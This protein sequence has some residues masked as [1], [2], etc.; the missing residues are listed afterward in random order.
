MAYG[1][2]AKATLGVDTSQVPQD[3]AKARAAFKK[4]ADDIAQDSSAH[5]ANAGEKFV[6]GVEHKLL[7]ASHLSTAFATA[8]GLNVEK[9][10]DSIAE[11][12]TRGSKEGW[13][14]A[15]D[16]AEEN[17]KLIASRVEAGMS[18]KQ[19]GDH[20]KRE[21]QK[22]VEEQAS[23][24]KQFSTRE[25]FVPGR[26]EAGGGYAPGTTRTVAN[27]ELTAEQTEKL[28]EAR[29][30]VL[31]IENRLA[32]MQKEE[33]KEIKQLEDQSLDVAEKKGTL[34]ERQQAIQSHMAIIEKQ[35]ESGSLT[36]VEIARKKV[37]LDQKRNDLEE[38]HRQM[39]Q[40][41]IDD[42]KRA[43]ELQSKANELARQRIE[44]QKD[45]DKLTDRSKL[46]VGELAALATNKATASQQDAAEAEAARAK[47]FQF[48]RDADLTPE[49]VKA[50]DQAEEIERLQ[51]KAER[52]RLS[53][54]Q[55]GA[56]AA[57]DQ[58][59]TLRESLVKSGFT[60]STEG[61]PAKLLLEQVKKDNEQVIKTL[62]EIKTLEAGKYVNQ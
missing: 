53:G 58:V 27:T 31:E 34:L 28:E 2:E 9:I 48:G 52:A 19:L 6:K 10:A 22:A 30:R 33:K 39:R 57:L 51:R 59:G 11:A 13:K 4:G 18:Q 35:I 40:K 37:E 15:G 23:L 60:K 14:R 20:L 32:E 44:L 26:R 29:K 17:A 61:D 55:A 1:S 62:G 7:G 43:N 5:G 42:E 54:D 49:Q 41:A 56:N 38:V 24:A 36:E 45:K 8:L 50:R 16:I 46:T 21:L 25:E 47:S 12:I 3:M